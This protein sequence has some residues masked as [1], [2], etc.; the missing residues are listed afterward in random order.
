MTKVRPDNWLEVRLQPDNELVGWLSDRCASVMRGG[1]TLS[2]TADADVIAGWHD[3]FGA[4]PGKLLSVSGFLLTREF[5]DSECARDRNLVET[6][7]SS[8]HHPTYAKME[9]SRSTHFAT[10]GVSIAWLVLKVEIETYEWLFDR[11]EFVP[12]M[13]W[14]DHDDRCRAAAATPYVDPRTKRPYAAVASGLK[15]SYRRSAERGV[16]S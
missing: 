11:D 16:G 6:W 5:S 7:I 9:R 3:D 10:Q 4:P 1:A 14:R 13:D 8:L 12:F 15:G 2:F